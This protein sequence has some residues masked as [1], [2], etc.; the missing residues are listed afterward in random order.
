MLS[1][2]AL[3]LLLGAAPAVAAEP[4]FTTIDV[5]GSTFTFPFAINPAGEIVGLYFDANDVGH[6]FLLSNGNFTT[7]EF[8]GATFT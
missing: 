3:N 5:P 4:T 7:I 8:Q 1:L 6:G 2:V